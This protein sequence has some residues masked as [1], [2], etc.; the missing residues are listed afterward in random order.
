MLSREPLEM[1]HALFQGVLSKEKIV[2]LNGGESRCN[3]FE[4]YSW[5]D[6]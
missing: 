4:V 1:N 3:E 5:G 6:G 2:C